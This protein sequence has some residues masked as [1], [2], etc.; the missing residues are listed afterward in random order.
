MQLYFVDV[1]W[2]AERAAVE[3]AYHWAYFV[4]CITTPFVF[5]VFCNVNL[6]AELRRSLR[7]RAETTGSRVG[8]RT[9]RRIGYRKWGQAANREWGPMAD[10]KTRQT[11][12]RKSG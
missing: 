10:R 7:M 12:D 8:R 9:G 1:G 5:L 6:I 2:L 4:V 3:R 11:E